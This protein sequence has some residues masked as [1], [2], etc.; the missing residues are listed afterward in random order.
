M[1]VRYVVTCSELTKDYGSGNGLFSLNL[2]IAEGEVFGLVGPNGAGK[3]T[4]IKLLMDLVIPTS[5]SATIF[6]KDSQRDFH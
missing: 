1:S 4:F 5:G 6:G 3:S 2:A